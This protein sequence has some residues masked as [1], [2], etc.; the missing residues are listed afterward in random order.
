M[1]NVPRVPRKS[2]VTK[3][4]EILNSA[5][6]P[7]KCTWT[8]SLMTP[9]RPRQFWRL[10]F[11]LKSLILWQLLPTLKDSYSFLTTSK[12]FCCRLS[13]IS[14]QALLITVAYAQDLLRWRWT[15]RNQR[16]ISRTWELLSRRQTA[17]NPLSIKVT[18][19]WH[20]AILAVSTSRGKS[21]LA[22]S[23]PPQSRRGHPKLFASSRVHQRRMAIT[24][25][26]LT[27]SCQSD[28]SLRHVD[29]VSSNTSSLIPNWSWL[30]GPVE[31]FWLSMIQWGIQQAWS[32]IRTTTSSKT[33]LGSSL[34]LNSQYRYKFTLSSRA[35]TTLLRASI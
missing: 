2:L 31:D 30:L 22:Q 34:T 13:R 5:K 19:L 9:C 3:R 26:P 17:L 21:P 29:Q 27:L 11:K 8:L 23:L 12:T 14:V 25:P 18:W 15:A 33:L 7:L 16:W 35:M 24:R 28:L 32:L 4:Q 1:A 6:T 10:L 20:R